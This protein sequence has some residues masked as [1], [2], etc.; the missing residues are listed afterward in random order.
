M[1]RIF[2]TFLTLMLMAGRV[3]AQDVGGAQAELIKQKAMHLR[4]VNNAQQ[5]IAPAPQSAPAYQPPTS[6]SPGINPA[7]QALI[8]RLETDLQIVKP[9]VPATPAQKLGL[10][11]D[12]TSLAKGVNKPSKANTAKLA[13]DLADTFADKTVTVKNLDQLGKIINIVINCAPLTQAR[14][15][16]FVVS[17][18]NILRSSAV[19]EANVKLIGGDLTAIIIEIQKNKPKLYQ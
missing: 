5:G 6:P 10:Q 13:A 16:T 18:E 11:T 9:G 2:I 3:L 4:D 12:L 15:Q 7:Q 19:S 14:A 17:A 8:D 1:N